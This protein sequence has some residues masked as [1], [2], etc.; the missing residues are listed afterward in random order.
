MQA[1]SWYTAAMNKESIYNSD[2]E[3]RLSRQLVF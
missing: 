3:K 1:E 2:I